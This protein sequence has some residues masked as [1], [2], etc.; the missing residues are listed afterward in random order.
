VVDISQA[1]ATDGI[2]IVRGRVQRVW[3]HLRWHYTPIPREFTIDHD[4]I[5]VTEG[6]FGTI[7]DFIGYTENSVVGNVFN[8]I[9]DGGRA[10]W[11]IDMPFTEP[12]PSLPNAPGH[13]TL[14]GTIFDISGNNVS[15]RDITVFNPRTGAWVPTSLIDASGSVTIQSNSIIVDRDRVVSANSLR[16]GQQIRVLTDTPINTVVIAS[17]LEA[18]GYIILVEG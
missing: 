15:L 8:V 6:G 18:D 1:P 16:V 12:I 4:T 13:L 2:Q 3:P 9:T 14:R 10:A 5:F 17:G 11:V 7:N